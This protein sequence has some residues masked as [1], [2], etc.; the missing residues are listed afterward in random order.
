MEIFLGI[1][2]IIVFL[3]FIYSI[4]CNVCIIEYNNDKED[5][6]NK[7]DSFK[8]NFECLKD[9]CFFN[10]GNFVKMLDLLSYRIDDL[11]N[12]FDK[13]SKKKKG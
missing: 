9:R 1:L 13:L 5:F 12:E 3:L 8:F 2:Y 4:I 11:E 7:L 6:K 10:D